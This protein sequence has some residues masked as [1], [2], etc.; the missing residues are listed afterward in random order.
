[1]GHHSRLN[2]PH[3]GAF[4]MAAL[5]LAPLWEGN[6]KQT[7]KIGLRVLPGGAG[8]AGGRAQEMLDVW[9]LRYGPLQNGTGS[10]EQLLLWRL[11]K[12]VVRRHS[13]FT[14]GCTV[15]S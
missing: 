12:S 14:G 8:R 9:Q 6:S 2:L 11:E 10:S 1:M 4:H 5:L 13:V 7:S 15:V 3:R